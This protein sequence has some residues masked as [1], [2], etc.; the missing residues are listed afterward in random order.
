MLLI[1]LLEYLAATI[2]GTILKPHYFERM[3]KIMK[4]KIFA[5]AILVIC[6]AVAAYGTLAY[7]THEETVTN[8]ITTGGVKIAIEEFSKTADGSTVPFENVDNVMPGTD[9]SKIVQIKNIGK[10]SAWV[11]VS[12]DVAI[13]LAEG[14]VGEVDLSLLDLDINTQNWT[15]KDGYYYYNTAL[16][17]GM[18]TEP[19]FTT[20]SFSI[21]MGNIYQNS[22]STVEINAQATQVANNGTTVFEAAG[23]PAQQ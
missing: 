23:W 19:L 15:E 17:A 2:L 1:Q 18:T 3:E 10:S 4:K 14:V 6:L 8:V 9:V 16:E 13:E 21:E 20:V 12:V 5:I 7:F 22:K 11:R